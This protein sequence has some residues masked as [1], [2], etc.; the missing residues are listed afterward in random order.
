MINLIIATDLGWGIGNNNQL[1]YHFS[2]DL[3]R[4]KLLTSGSPVV[5]GRKTWESLPKKLPNRT[6]IVI[7][8]ATELPNNPDHIYSDITPVLELAKHETVWVIGGAAIAELFLPYTQRIELTL[9]MDRQDADTK[10]LF[11]EKALRDY[12]LMEES[13]HHEI[14][15]ISQVVKQYYFQTHIKHN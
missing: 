10:I 7:S 15:K 14:D 11:M 5:M 6:N 2:N 8:S 1:L 12:I 13:E 9:V 3:K 4:F